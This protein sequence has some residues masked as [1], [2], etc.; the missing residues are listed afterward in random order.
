[1][2]REAGL[3][4]TT[5]SLSIVVTETCREPYLARAT[6]CRPLAIYLPWASLASLLEQVYR[7]LP[8]RRRLLTTPS[9]R[10]FPAATRQSALRPERRKTSPMCPR[11]HSAVPTAIASPHRHEDG[12]TVF[13]APTP[14]CDRPVLAV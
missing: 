5:L 14:E 11:T 9:L 7:S 12:C 8:Q 3:L 1:M 6:W 2:Q 4:L 13:G 10:P